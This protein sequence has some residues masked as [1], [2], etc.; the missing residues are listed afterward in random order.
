MFN[1]FTMP[2]LCKEYWLSDIQVTQIKNWTWITWTRGIK[3]MIN[4][5]LFEREY[6]KPKFSSLIEKPRAFIKL[7]V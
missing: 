1:L 3:I 2:H 4:D 5:I 7:F 6:K